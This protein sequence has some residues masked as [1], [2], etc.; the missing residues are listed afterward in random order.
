MLVYSYSTLYYRVIP[1]IYIYLYIYIFLGWLNVI[2]QYFYKQNKQ[3]WIL[4]AI[5]LRVEYKRWIFFPPRL[6]CVIPSHLFIYRSTPPP[7]PLP[8]PPPP[9]LS[10]YHIC[11]TQPPCW[12]VGVRNPHQPTG[13]DVGDNL[14][15]KS[16]WTFFF[17]IQG[18]MVL[19]VLVG[20][21][22]VAQ[23]YD[24]EWG[25]YFSR[26]LS[27][28]RVKKVMMMRC[29]LSLAHPSPPGPSGTIL[30]S[31]AHGIYTPLATIDR[32]KLHLLPHDPLGNSDRERSGEKKKKK[33]KNPNSS[34][35]HPK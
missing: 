6:R 1:V 18:V 30:M 27:I 35:S 20:K 21:S 4:F 13:K 31:S 2:K 5:T 25:L 26:S 14:G 8:P 10:P 16:C 22:Q 33:K 32:R 7:P 3:S 12:W 15:F 34:I 9:S 17:F 29:F 23:L 28:P 19:V 24:D 11:L